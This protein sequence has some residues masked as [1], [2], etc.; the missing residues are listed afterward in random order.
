M[1]ILDPKKIVSRKKKV[2]LS[3]FY[4]LEDWNRKRI[5]P[6]AITYKG[7]FESR[8]NENNSY[9]QAGYI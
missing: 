1:V 7:P 6:N 8:R 5:Y 9:P 3:R 2:V 4:K